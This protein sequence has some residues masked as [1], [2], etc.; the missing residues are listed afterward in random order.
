MIRYVN[1]N[2]DISDSNKSGKR[3]ERGGSSKRERERERERKRERER[4][5]KRERERGMGERRGKSTH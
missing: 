1:L 2:T 3:E 4:E 5:R